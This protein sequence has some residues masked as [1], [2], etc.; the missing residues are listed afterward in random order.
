[1]DTDPVWARPPGGRKPKLTREAIVAAAIEIADAEG[2]EAVSIRRVA[3]ELGVRAMSLY[4]HIDRKEDLLD[5]MYDEVAG[6]ALV[7]GEPPGDWRAAFLQICR[8]ERATAQRHA[9]MFELASRSPRVG[10]NGLCHA[11]QSL[12]AAA[13]LTD[14]LEAQMEIVAAVDR[15]MLGFVIRERRPEAAEAGPKPKLLDVSYVRALL[16]LGE[17]RHLKPALKAGVREPDDFEKGLNWL[18]DGI[19]REYGGS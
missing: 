7:E 18:L 14:D 15:Y 2:L 8:K 13:R 4:T 16:E 6:E 11:D 5:L 19:E 12:G 10:P 9:W 17:Y 1:M 3:A